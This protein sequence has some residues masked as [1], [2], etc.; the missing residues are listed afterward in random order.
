MI[1]VR[2]L[3]DVHAG[4][5]RPALLGSVKGNLGHL[6][7]GAPG[8]GGGAAAAGGRWPGGGRRAAGR[9]RRSC[10]SRSG[11]GRARRDRRAS[12]AAWPPGSGWEW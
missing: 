9:T 12:R 5:D 8:G 1:E 10:R 4:R 2:A 3:G 7:G 6:A 11:R